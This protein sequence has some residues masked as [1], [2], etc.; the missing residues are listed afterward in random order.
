MYRWEIRIQEERWLAEE[1]LCLED[2]LVLAVSWKPNSFF[3][4]FY[5]FLFMDT[6]MAYGSSLARD[7]LWA[8]AATQARA[9]GMP[10]LF[11]PLHWDGDPACTSCNNPSGCRQILSPLRHSRNSKNQIILELDPASLNIPRCLHS[12]SNSKLLLSLLPSSVHL[13][14]RLFEIY[15]HINLT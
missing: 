7:W 8:A 11:N 6:C 10:D 13:T 15:M 5:F 3:F 12:L 4:F 2:S 14:R 9:S 1:K